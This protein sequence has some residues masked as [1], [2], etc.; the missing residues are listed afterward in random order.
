MKTRWI[1]LMAALFLAAGCAAMQP[2]TTGSVERGAWI[3]SKISEAERLGAKECSPRQLAKAKVALEHVMH[4]VK[5]GYYTDAWLE[6]EF[7]HADKFADELLAERRLAA[8]LGRPFRCVSAS[9]RGREGRWRHEEPAGSAEPA[10]AAREEQLA[11]W[12]AGD[13]LNASWGLR[14]QAYPFPIT[15]D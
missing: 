11:P 15:A 5:E 4:E 12:P 7:E 1:M 3:A 13:Y 8:S 10:P 6:P 14:S 2:K 9:P